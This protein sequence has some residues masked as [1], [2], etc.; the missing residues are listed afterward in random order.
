[1]KNLKIGF[2]STFTPDSNY[3]QFLGE[4]INS[5][6]RNLDLL[7]YAPSNEDISNLKV[8]NKKN[9]W[10]KFLYPIQI[11]LMSLKDQLDVIHFQYE[12]NMYGSVVFSTFFPLALFLQKLIRR[13]VI[14]TMHVVVSENEINDDFKSTFNAKNIPASFIKTWFYIN[15]FFTVFF[16][17]SVIV[18]SGC[19]K[20]I[21]LKD[22]KARKADKIFI[23]HLGVPI[24]KTHDYKKIVNKLLG[25]YENKK[26][27]LSF[28]YITKRKGLGYLVEAF[29]RLSKKHKNIILVIAGG[30]L[31]YERKYVESLKDRIKNKKVIVILDKFL[32]LEE[33]KAL[34]SNTYISVFPY[35][36]SISAS[37]CSAFSIS[38]LT[39]LVLTDIGSFRDDVEKD[40]IGL[41]VRKRNASDLQNAIETLISDGKRYNKIKENMRKVRKEREWTNIAVKTIS[42]YKTHG[43]DTI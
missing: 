7:C 14:V 34:Y 3:S 8:K 4:A 16:S 12:F 32:T 6:D 39:P 18:H 20:E 36:Y 1:M 22:Y 27:I 10:N 26:M 13:K 43:I 24:Y 28:G 33:I 9:F 23:V 15:Y 5:L 42:L 11:F 41:L 2:V 25:N 19:F 38:Y 35:T 31:E 17:D 37:A 29:E 40:S 21:L 30:V